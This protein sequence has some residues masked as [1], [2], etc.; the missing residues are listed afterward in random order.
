MEGGKRE[1]K[2]GWGF[3][4]SREKQYQEGEV[5]KAILMPDFFKNKGKAG[6]VQLLFGLERLLFNSK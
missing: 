1:Q 6:W 3:Y 4:F 5:S 2:A